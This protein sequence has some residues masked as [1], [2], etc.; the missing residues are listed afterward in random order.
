MG[1]SQ[2][3]PMH[4][5]S[6]MSMAFNIIIMKKNQNML[7]INNMKACKLNGSL[8]I[9]TKNHE[10]KFLGSKPRWSSHQTP[11][12]SDASKIVTI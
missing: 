7:K 5:N 10:G 4:F 8:E 6:L 1:V 11:L 12:E 2:R 3:L 9:V